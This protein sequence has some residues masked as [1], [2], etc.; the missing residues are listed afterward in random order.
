MNISNT[1][2]LS[3]RRP[4]GCWLRGSECIAKATCPNVCQFSF[5][6]QKLGEPRQNRCQSC[7]EKRNGIKGQLSL[8]GFSPQ[9]YPFEHK[10]SNMPDL[11]ERRLI[12]KGPGWM[13][14]WLHSSWHNIVLKFLALEEETFS[15]VGQ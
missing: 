9:F 3:I 8:L 10:P 13:I 14:V 4:L 15:F 7:L 12:E 6:Q 5:S 11:G 1:Q 2:M